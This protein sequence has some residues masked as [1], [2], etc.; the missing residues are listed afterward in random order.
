MYPHETLTVAQ[1]T[2]SSMIHMR[3]ITAAINKYDTLSYDQIA[4][5]MVIP[6]DAATMFVDEYRRARQLD[7]KIRAPH[8]EEGAPKM[9]Y[10][11]SAEQSMIYRYAQQGNWANR[12]VMALTPCVRAEPM[13]DQSHFEVFLKLELATWGNE[14]TTAN[15]FKMVLEA[16]SVMEYVL[17]KCATG[18]RSTHNVVELKIVRDPN[19]DHECVDLMMCSV[20]KP[21]IQIEVG[22]YG[23]REIEGVRGAYVYGTGIAEPRFGWAVN[24]ILNQQ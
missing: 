4:V 23:I 6:H 5:P 21:D 19:A 1:V 15:H 16:K 11:G 14:V 18:D 12:K 10:V 8:I 13:C 3:Y 7:H 2:D 20:R 22:S 17:T 9:A 24:Y